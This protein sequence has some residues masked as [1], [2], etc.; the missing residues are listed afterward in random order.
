MVDTPRIEAMGLNL[1]IINAFVPHQGPT[2][3]TG[4]PAAV[5][6]LT[7]AE[8]ESL[9]DDVRGEIAHELNLSETAFVTKQ[10]SGKFFIRWFTPTREVELCGHATLAAAH[11][12]LEMKWV[13]YGQV[14][15]FETNDVGPLLVET[16][17]PNSGVAEGV[18]NPG[19]AP[20][21]RMQFP[22]LEAQTELEHSYQSYVRDAFE[23]I[24]E[25]DVVRMYR[26]DY[27]VVMQV[28]TAEIVETETPAFED[29][30]C[31]QE[32]DVRGLIVTADASGDER[33][34]ADFVSRFFAPGVGI[35]ED[36]V[37]GSAHC[38]LAMLYMK[39]GQTATGLQL[40][41]RGGMVNLKREGD[42]VLLMGWANTIIRGKLTHPEVCDEPAFEDETAEENSSRM[43]SYF[44]S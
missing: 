21:L 1:F 39:D 34:E 41:G 33:F 24:E 44:K 8:C 6:L 19:Q 26:S 40:S 30:K 3:G 16:G 4:N 14:V 28:R 2:F 29:L 37:T 7:S 17:G 31:L 27:D 15:E 42:K 20:P 35:N 13:S 9:T 12:L 22:L 43:M 38:A 23:E 25:E 18:V 11:A 10:K 32:L 5:V 36:P